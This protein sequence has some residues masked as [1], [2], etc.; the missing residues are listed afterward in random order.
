MPELDKIAD[1]GVR[2]LL[3]Q[4]HDK[5]RGGETVG[6][7]HAS[8]DGFLRLWALHPDALVRFAD[9]S[10]HNEIPVTQHWPGRACS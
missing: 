7:V 2:A 3:Q 9:P 10:R 4:A 6:A 8:V 1:A 5:L